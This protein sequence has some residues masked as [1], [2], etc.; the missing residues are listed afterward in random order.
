MIFY[1]SGKPSFKPGQ[2]TWKLAAGLLQE[3]QTLVLSL[4]TRH[5]FLLEWRDEA[6]L[7]PIETTLTGNEARLFHAIWDAYPD[8]CDRSEVMKTLDMPRQLVWRTAASLRK[9]LRCFGIESVVCEH[10][11]L[12]VAYGGGARTEAS[13]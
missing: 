5:L 3:H 12:L 2:T 9:K 11:Y 6:V 4:T 8:V 7:L 13:R 10:G 1:L